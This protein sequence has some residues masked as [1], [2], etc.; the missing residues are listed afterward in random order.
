MATFSADS[1]IIEHKVRWDDFFFLSL[2]LANLIDWSKYNFIHPIIRGGIC[3]SFEL[4]TVSHLP[5]I[6]ELSEL[7]EY[8][9]STT[10][11]VD[12][13]CDSGA[14][15]EPFMRDGYDCAVLHYA[16]HSK[17]PTYYAEKS[18]GWMVYP[19]EESDEISKTV[20]RQIQY[21]GDNPG[22]AGVIETPKRV[23]KSWN[24]LYRGYRDDPRKILSKQFDVS[25][26]NAS[27]EPVLLENI[28]FYSTCEHHLL[29]FFG[30]ISVG[31]IPN[32]KVVGISK[33]AR[34]VDCFSRRLQIQERLCEQIADAIQEELAPFG[35]YVKA[36]ARHLCMIARGVSKQNAEMTS[37]AVRGE[38]ESIQ[39]I[40]Q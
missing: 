25:R 19:W 23:V 2:K 8:E 28:E 14:T 4:S 27:S 18:N 9:K 1:Q 32:Q 38:Y 5:I 20:T 3:L 24:E 21:V 15:L 29:P 39:K 22:R 31:Y 10:L 34:L 7:S 6:W 12:D 35:V 26:S 13:I 40:M 16:G 37:V 17:P 33:L 36:K 11:I 30:T